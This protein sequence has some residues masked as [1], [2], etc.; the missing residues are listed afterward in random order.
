MDDDISENLKI[1]KEYGVDD[2]P[3][4][5]QDKVFTSDGDMTYI[6]NMPT[7]IH[8]HLGNTYM[9]N[10]VVSPILKAHK[11]LT[12]FRIL[13]A[14]NARIM[15][16]SFSDKRD[17][18]QIATDG[19]LMEKPLKSNLIKI[20][21]AERVEILVD[22]SD[23]MD[24]LFLTDYA[25]GSHV[26]IMKINSK[27]AKKSEYKIPKKLTK[28]EWIKEEEATKH[29]DMVLSM[30][31]GTLR[32]NNK[33]YSHSRIDEKVKINSTEIWTIST[34]LAPMAHPFHIHGTSFQILSRNGKAPLP[35]ERG[36]KDI[37]L[38]DRGEEVKVI[39][40][41]KRPMQIRSA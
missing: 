10:G 30:E 33:T 9:V 3:L 31:E 16:I 6:L 1:P 5:I 22:L 27:N 32:V 11:T 23:G 14:S 19:G 41:F 37:V 26:N 21:P 39:M 40:R 25:S 34:N 17:F 7:R 4:I 20:S 18:Y 24:D 2:I 36:W 8:G 38:V 15:D 35:S 28:I 29:R 12:R 13:N